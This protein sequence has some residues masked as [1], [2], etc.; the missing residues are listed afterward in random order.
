MSALERVCGR[1]GKEVKEWC[2]TFVPELNCPVGLALH[3]DCQLN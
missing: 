3:P 1:E 2:I